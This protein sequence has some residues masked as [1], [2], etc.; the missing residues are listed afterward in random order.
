MAEEPKVQW[1][2]TTNILFEE[3][4]PTEY[5]EMADEA[6]S[7][8]RRLRKSEERTNLLLCLLQMG[9]AR[10]AT[11]KTMPASPIA[12]AQS[13]M[14]VAK[15]L[16]PFVLSI[17]GPDRQ[18]FREMKVENIER[19]INRNIDYRNIDD[20]ED[21][22][23]DR[24]GDPDFNPN[25]GAVARNLDVRGLY[26]QEL[27]ERPVLFQPA[28]Y[29]INDVGLG[30]LIAQGY[31][32]YLELQRM[33]VMGTTNTYYTTPTMGPGGSDVKGFYSTAWT[34]ID[35]TQIDLL[36]S[37]EQWAD[38]DILANAEKS[39]DLAA[40]I[41]GKDWE[42]AWVQQPRK[43]IF[44]R[45]VLEGLGL[46][47][48]VVDTLVKGID[49]TQKGGKR[50]A[51]R[52]RDSLAEYW[53]EEL[54]SVEAAQTYVEEMILR[55]A[56]L[57]LRNTMDKQTGLVERTSELLTS[58]AD[59]FVE[60]LVEL[61]L[62]A[63]DKSTKDA[64]VGMAVTEIKRRWELIDLLDYKMC[65]HLHHYDLTHQMAQ[66]GE[67]EYP[68]GNELDMVPLQFHEAEDYIDMVFE[69]TEI[70]SF[71]E[72][73]LECVDQF[74]KACAVFHKACSAVNADA[75]EAIIVNP[76]SGLTSE[77]SLNFTN[78]GV[79]ITNFVPFKLEP[80]KS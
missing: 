34:S 12:E 75:T 10:I 37:S 17:E 8:G 19:L 3:V 47:S 16:Q 13:S 40:A 39:A 27:Q 74:N 48:A 29:T 50:A 24:S 58:M 78:N 36:N 71:T 42:A 4:L 55:E 6:I 53:E 21:H 25:R 72:Q 51:K 31:D 68:T 38:S 22:P 14:E 2:E 1:R 35:M 63:R 77:V 57:L 15:V 61:E 59:T 76:L 64:V 18:P 80:R 52:V 62:T 79:R 20:Y 5:K 11:S 54:G 66:A 9:T 43:D 23:E 67:E 60:P 28:N 44:V 49:P 70:D 45:N 73:M 56:W 7:R 41:A 46:P 69:E 32:C 30:Y 65:E 33:V 26:R